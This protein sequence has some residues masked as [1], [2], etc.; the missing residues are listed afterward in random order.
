M[1]KLMCVAA[2]S[3]LSLLTYAQQPA[4]KPLDHSVYDGWQSIGSKS[5]SN[6]GQWIVYTVTPQEGDATLFIY[7]NKTKQHLEAPRGANPVITEDSRYV[8][9]AIKTPY[10]VTRQ[11]K[12][13]KKKTSEMPKDSL[14]IVTLATGNFFKVPSVRSFKTPEKGTGVMAYLKE[15]P[16]ADT[17]SGHLVIQYLDKQSADTIRNVQDYQFSKTG[18]RLVAETVADK[19][20]SLSRAAVLLWDVAAHKADT[21]S[22]GTA[23]RKQ[24]AFD[25]AGKQLA[26]CSSRDSVKA[27]QHFYALY[28]YRQGQDSG[29]IT[30]DKG[31]AAFPAN[32]SVSPDGKVWFS[33]NGQRLFFGTAPVA[34]PKDTNIVD[35]EVAKVDIWN[36]KDD[37][38]QPMQLKN[39]DKELKRSYQAVYYPG[40]KKV[41]QLADKDM[42]NLATADKGNSPYALGY[43][44]KGQR[45]SMQWTGHS[46][47][48]SYLVN[49]QD[50]NRKLLQQNLDSVSRISPAGRYI[51]WYNLQQKQWY[52]YET[53][54]GTTR[55]IT[56]KIP[57]SLSEEDDDH[58]D[59]PAPYGIAAWLED[60]K[61]VYIYDRYDIWQVDPSGKSAPQ[62]LTA[63][64]GREQKLR[65]RYVKL[66]KEARFINAGEQMLLETFN[67]TTKENGFYT[68]NSTFKKSPVKPSLVV[69]GPY[70]Y[71]DPV[72]AENADN[73]IFTRANYVS[74]PD[75]YTATSLDKAEQISHINPQQKEYNWGTA[76]LFKWTA[77]NGKPAEGILYKPE[78]FD[79]TKKYPVL[80]YF[81]EKLS[82]GLYNYM[83]PA[84]TPSRLNISFFVSR[85]YLVLAPDISYENGYPGQGA[86]DY[87][88]SGARALAANPWADSLHM[89][90]QGQSWGGYQVAHLITRTSLFK[91]AWAGAPV[92]NM[93]SAYG[94]IRWE[95]GM[96]RQFQYERSQ[97]RIGATLWEKPELYIENSPLF[98]LP[99]VT[100]PLAIMSNDADG[101]VPWYQGIELFTGLR[102]LGKPVWMLN[103]NNEAHNLIHRQNRKDIQRREQQFFDHFLKNAPAPE[104]MEVGVP[105]TEKGRN[106]GW[107]TE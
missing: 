57:V 70:S 45:V 42:E 66:D 33:E 61:A 84:P 83:P 7:N 74:S 19:K 81:Y 104:W 105:A 53:A 41:I 13:K 2:L 92:A 36:Y 58:P 40:S 5:I 51:T 8:I 103:Y 98:H 54:T 55:N 106:W 1:K 22:R 30:A 28:Y 15:K 59:M 63:G 85:G 47:K 21:I 78:D 20:D 101:A 46:L 35:F 80:L 71:S 27:L 23:L 100:T 50:G 72:K 82:E 3:G 88:V 26:W 4:K 95:S 96:N 37:Y 39:L 107:E 90:I 56:E 38:L 62:L 25:D 31:N 9:F 11:A 69:M 17:T 75:L 24:F 67:E 64:Y 94:G 29:I 16:Q 48:T 93:T 86:Y 79:S 68:T 32:W 34:P 12:I 73:Y 18:N 76:E 52:A 102:R 87:I 14:G 97:S 6:N 89:G 77:Y 10:A 91:A 99:K 60:D 49:L 65:F 44:D 43:T